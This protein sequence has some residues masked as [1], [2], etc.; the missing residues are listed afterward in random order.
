LVLFFSL[1]IGSILLLSG[2]TA[3]GGGGSKGRIRVASK[4][5]TEQYILGNL[6]QILLQ[7]AGFEVTY[8]PAGGSAEVHRA[9]VEGEIDVYP[10]YTG[11]ALS[12]HL[13]MEYDPSMTPDDVYQV[14]K[15]EFEKQWGLTLLE[16][17][18]FNNTYCLAMRRDQADA[19]GISTLSDLSTRASELTFITT[20][21]FTER[22]DGLPGLQALYGG[23]Q[24]K[25]VRAVDQG[26]RYAGIAEGEVDVTTCNGTDGQ[27]SA[28]DL[29]IIEDDKR[30]WPPYPVAPVVRQEVLEKYPDVATALNKVA[31]LLDDVTMSRLNWEV[32]GNKDEPDEVARAFL[33]ENG[34]IK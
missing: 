23:F 33:V 6:Y 31:P 4:E 16:P 27:I 3:I 26:L 25:E 32:T 8:Q 2:C 14:V 18:R 30:F 29:K 7:D 17:T 21:E 34:L 19:M 11:T 10:E 20:Q 13:K 22:V 5:F 12:A 28:L 24:F 9:I 15:D 1:L